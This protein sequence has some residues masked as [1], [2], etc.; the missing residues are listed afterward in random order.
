MTS[1]CGWRYENT[2]GRSPEK[3][4]QVGTQRGF[5]GTRGVLLATAGGVSADQDGIASGTDTAGDG[6][7]F[8]LDRRRKR[9]S[10]QPTF[11]GPA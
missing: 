3:E 2:R 1:A 7:L 11:A 6:R 10:L 8:L 5:I 4:L 9:E